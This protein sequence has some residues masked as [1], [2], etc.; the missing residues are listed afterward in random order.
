MIHIQDLS[1]RFEQ[2]VLFE[3]Y[4]LTIAKGERVVLT[5]ESGSGKTSLLHCLTGFTVPQSGEIRLNELPVTP[6]HIDAVR[7]IIGYLPQE[8]TLDLPKGKDLLLYPFAF[9]ANRSKHPSLEQIEMLLSDL[10]LPKECMNQPIVELSGGQKQRLLFA[11][12]WLLDRPILL[13]DE[14]TSA[15]DDTSTAAMI[16]LIRT[17]PHCTVVSVSHDR[18][19]I[20]AM[21]R[22]IVVTNPSKIFQTNL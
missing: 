8:V 2:R 11:S 20:E 10:L 9:R 18:R 13:L 7:Q 5:G 17:R 21:D 4:D 22:N 19:W 14:P 12:I 6:E 15:L 3:N 16:S 1:L